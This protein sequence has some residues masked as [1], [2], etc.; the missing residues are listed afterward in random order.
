[1]RAK[2]NWRRILG[3]VLASGFV[4]L[5]LWMRPWA[6]SVMTVRVTLATDTQPA[7]VLYSARKLFR[8]EAKR[9][10]IFR[11]DID[12]S[13]WEGQLVLLDIDGN[14]TRRELEH[15]ST[16]YVACEAQLEDREGSCPVE[17]VGW[18]QN[19]EAALHCGPVGPL[20]CRVPGSAAGRFAF[21]KKGT[22][23]HAFRVPRGARLV[24]RFRPIPLLR[25]EGAV[26]PYLPIDPGA[27]EASTRW[28]ARSPERPPDVFIYVID[29]VRADHLGCH[30]YDRETSPAVDAFAAEAVL[31]EDGHTATTWTRPSVATILS[32]LYA[33]VHGAMHYA[34]GL[35]DWPVLLS[36]MLR[37]AGYATRAFV[38]NA[39]VAAPMGFDQGW[40]ELVFEHSTADWVNRMVERALDK[41]DPE[42]PVFM[43]LH[44][45]EPHAPYSPHPES[46]RLFDRGYEG[47]CD[48]SRE[49]LDA[50][51]VLHPDLSEEDVQHLLDRYDAEIYEADQG[52]AKFVD[53]LRRAGRYENS[54]IVLV[55]D[56]GE[57]FTEH[58][59]LGHAWELNQEDMHILFVVR[60][61]HNRHGGRR[62]RE[63][64]SLVDIMP[65]VLSE[66]GLRPELPYE[67]PG[68]NLARLAQLAEPEANRRI[69]A[70][71][72]RWDSNDLDLV[73]VIDED[74]Y[75]RVVDVSVPPRETA[76]K[77]SLGLWD[78]H[79]DPRE[80]TDLAD[81][82]P[83]RAAY[84]ELLLARWLLRQRDWREKVGAAPPPRLEID[85]GLKQQLRALGYV[86]GGPP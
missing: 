65:T 9:L 80:E 33:S 85:D 10:P 4:A 23:W 35:A 86:G 1:M 2:R 70:E 56:H 24:L 53:V 22:L 48:G 76:A 38:T 29:A 15:G 37:D 45:V 73:A 49:A 41:E 54:L 69:Y 61:P 26:E 34:D 74:G 77:K 55:S 79:A 18:H 81:T 60:F 20:S 21:A 17:F 83:V 39:N 31:F 40:D 78:T 6:R 11:A 57:A 82:L 72:S 13:Q 12:L 66:V 30:G 42:R 58:D 68:R 16:G 7:V 44:T 46:F 5:L 32:G 47:R 52:F 50:L 36:E 67:L 3:L 28:P 59:T 14:L 51:D 27:E 64:S 25:I 19:L 75:K 62:V 71:V 63:R 8:E 84:D 43:Y